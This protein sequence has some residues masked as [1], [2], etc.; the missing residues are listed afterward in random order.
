MTP[1]E[2]CRNK[3]A[4]AGSSLY[5][6][7]L[8]HT[9]SERRKLQA[10][11]ALQYELN[12]VVCRASDPGAAR[13]TL[14][15][16][17]EEINRLFA[18]A[19]R[20]P[21]TRELAELEHADYLTQQGL[22]GCVAATSQFLDAPESG[23]YP[24]WLA[25]HEHASGYIWHAAGMVCGSTD[26]SQLGTLTRA[27]CCHGAFELLHHVRHF[28]ALGLNPLPT[29]LLAE[30]HLN[31][32]TIIRAESHVSAKNLFEALFARLCEDTGEYLTQLEQ[33]NPHH[34]PLFSRTLLHILYTL[35]RK[36]Q[37]AK[38]PITQEHHS[39]TPLRKL[40]IALKNRGQGTKVNHSPPPDP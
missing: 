29:D 30:C 22:L 20:H 40:W 6:A 14:Y 36:Y 11:F 26:L 4:P 19:A 18:G 8:Y 33:T 7:G 39:L 24:D 10:L 15:W 1:A 35:C 32:E 17:F 37:R 16:W 12:D 38:R 3:A 23:P 34:S 2:Y 27:G 25:R 5:Y 21:I 13:V 9:P 31:L 28:A